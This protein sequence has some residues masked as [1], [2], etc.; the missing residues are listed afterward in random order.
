M[1][2]QE[3]QDDPG[4]REETN[5]H[6]DVTSWKLAHNMLLLVMMKNILI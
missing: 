1:D 6:E 4:K 2:S 3:T 5:T